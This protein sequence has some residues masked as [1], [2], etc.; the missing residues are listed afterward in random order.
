ML[1]TEISDG[2]NRGNK[3]RAK[4]A[5]MVNGSGPSGGLTDGGRP[6]RFFGRKVLTF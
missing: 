6:R 2:D 5:G 4:M 1:N 3:R